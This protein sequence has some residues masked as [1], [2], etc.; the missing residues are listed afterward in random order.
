[1]PGDDLID[2]EMSRARMVQERQQT[3]SQTGANSI[4]L[5]PGNFEVPQGREFRISV[6]LRSQEEIYNLSLNLSFDS[7]V[8]N[9]KQVTAGGFV[10]REGLDSSFLQNIDN[11]SGICTIAFSSPDI[12]KGVK[13]TGGIATLV[14]DA[15]E[16]G[17]S[18]VMINGIVGID[19]TGK[20]IVFGSQNAR[21]VVR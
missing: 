16:K 13:G 7:S 5:N 8:L 2:E 6:N 15:K 1:M 4:S 20:S 9:L 21:V 14:F 18:Q 17:E 3:S 11:G 19:T 10:R 12:T